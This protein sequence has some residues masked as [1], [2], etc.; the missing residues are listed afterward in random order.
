MG[1]RVYIYMCFHFAFNMP[2]F[3]VELCSNQ[4]M[5]AVHAQAYA[6]SSAAPFSSFDFASVLL[7]FAPKSIHQQ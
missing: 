4:R 7:C 5:P 3:I 1:V 2:M 6:C